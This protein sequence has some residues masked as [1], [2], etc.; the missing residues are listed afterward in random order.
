VAENGP[1]YILTV[2][3]LSYVTA[4]LGLA[5]N[6]GLVGT[7]ALREAGDLAHSVDVLEVL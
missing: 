2:F 5:E 7:L 3:V 6:V 4:E 1:F